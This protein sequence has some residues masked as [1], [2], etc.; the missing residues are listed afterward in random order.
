VLTKTEGNSPDDRI[1]KSGP[2]N[3]NIVVP[4]ERP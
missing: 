4:G 2:S 1:Q 3:G